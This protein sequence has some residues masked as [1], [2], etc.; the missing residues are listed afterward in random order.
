VAPVQAMECVECET[1]KLFCDA[2]HISISVRL[3]L[4]IAVCES[5]QRALVAMT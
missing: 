4:F 3:R 1:I 5:V 2:N